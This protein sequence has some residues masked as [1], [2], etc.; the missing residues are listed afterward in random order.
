MED[1]KF[2]HENKVRILKAKFLEEKRLFD[3]AMEDHIKAMADQ[4]NMVLSSLISCLVGSSS[5]SK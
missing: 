4:A 5:C 1:K 2:D 3:I